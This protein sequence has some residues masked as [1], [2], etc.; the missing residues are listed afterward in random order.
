MAFSILIYDDLM[1]EYSL[2]QAQESDIDSVLELD[3]ENMEQHVVRHYHII[4]DPNANRPIVQKNLG[5][6]K[7]LYYNEEFV[8]CYYWSCEIPEIAF[9]VSIQIREGYRGNGLGAKL[10]EIFEQDARNCGCEAVELT[11]FVD[12][13]AR[14]LYKRLDY[15]EVD[16]DHA[17]VMSKEL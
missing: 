13:P 5:R 16:K 14:N 7:V 4:F 6:T 2:K 9:L 12:S 1:K 17:V 3:K 10:M 11:V 15:K 8:G